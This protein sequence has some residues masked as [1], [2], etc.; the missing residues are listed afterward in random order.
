MLAMAHVPRLSRLISRWRSARRT[1]TRTGTTLNLYRAGMQKIRNGLFP[2]R[3][4]FVTDKRLSRF[5]ALVVVD[6]GDFTSA[7]QDLVFGLFGVGFDAIFGLFGRSIARS[8]FVT[9]SPIAAIRSRR[10]PV[11]TPSTRGLFARFF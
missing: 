3:D 7:E 2:G 1:G 11:A 5:V 4:I 6:F 10:R 8:L 9:A